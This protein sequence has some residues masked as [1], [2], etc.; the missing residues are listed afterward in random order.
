MHMALSNPRWS[1][2]IRYQ[3]VTSGDYKNRTISG[4]NI[5]GQSVLGKEGAD[6]TGYD[7]TQ[8][9]DF[10]RLYAQVNNGTFDRTTLTAQFEVS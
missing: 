5:D 7:E 4:V 10:A 6:E 8:A 1:I 9:D 2:G 3:D